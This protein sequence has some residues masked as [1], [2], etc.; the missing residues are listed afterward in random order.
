ML[1][2]IADVNVASA[3]GNA[4]SKWTDYVMKQKSKLGLKSVVIA[5]KSG[6]VVATSGRSQDISNN[7]IQVRAHKL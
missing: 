4:W 7:E 2:I 3:G 5:R 6:E 1:G